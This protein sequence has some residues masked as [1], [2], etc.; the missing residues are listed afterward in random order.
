MNNPLN[1]III[2][3]RLYTFF[4]ECRMPMRH[5]IAKAWRVTK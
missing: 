3:S 4:R 5:A 1:R 2:A